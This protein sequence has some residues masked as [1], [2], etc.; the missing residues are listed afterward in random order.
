[1]V[2]S[3]KNNS[4]P[5]SAFA[6]DSFEKSSISFKGDDV[7]AGKENTIITSEDL[8]IVRSTTDEF[9]QYLCP[10]A[11]PNKAADEFRKFGDFFRHTYFPEESMKNYQ[12]SRLC[13]TL[14]NIQAGIRAMIGAWQEDPDEGPD[15]IS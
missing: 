8:E 2:N 15:K 13:H 11:D 14:G 12:V 6:K 4:A 3:N 7:N 9:M 1:M 10:G 5:P